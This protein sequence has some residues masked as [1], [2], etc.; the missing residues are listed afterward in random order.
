MQVKSKAKRMLIN[1]FDI[2]RIAH[3]ELV[4][5]GQTATA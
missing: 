5:V 1:F 3:S 4:P 2:R